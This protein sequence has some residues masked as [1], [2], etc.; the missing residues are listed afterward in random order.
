MTEL[1]LPINNSK[2]SDRE[3]LAMQTDLNILSNRQ[4]AEIA[5][6]LMLK[7]QVALL[8]S[9]T[10]QPMIVVDEKME[11]KKN[12]F[13]IDELNSEVRR[14]QFNGKMAIEK[15]K[16]QKGKLKS[17]E[18]LSKKNV[19]SVLK[20]NRSSS[21]YAKKMKD[22]DLEIRKKYKEL[23]KNLSLKEAEKIRL[24]SE[25]RVIIA[26]NFRK[27]GN[28]EFDRMKIRSLNMA[29]AEKEEECRKRDILILD[30]KQKLRYI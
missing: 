28:K 12:E 23:E 27:E 4:R 3:Y 17:E 20:N 1:D 19:E 5:E 14:E 29:I 13:K 22:L 26:R 30:L 9:Q 7:N 24:E 18:M 10:V 15:L 21:D 2:Y 8:S 6:I 25:R 16:L 11:L